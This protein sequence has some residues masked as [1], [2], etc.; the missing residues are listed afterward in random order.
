[1]F[2]AKPD[3][4]YTDASTYDSANLSNIELGDELGAGVFIPI[5]N[6]FRY[7]GSWLTR[8]C[9]DSIDVCERVDSASS[10]FGALRKSIFSSV[11]ISLL[12]KRFVYNTLILPV[13][14]YGS[15]TWCL[16][17]KSFNQLRKFHA[18][19]TRAMCRVNLLHTREHRISTAELL[20]R[21]GLNTID[22]IVTRN[23]LRWAGHVM[24]MGSERLPRKMIT[25][26]VCNPRPRGA[27]EFTYGRGLYKA[28]K[29]TNIPKGKWAT[30]V[31]DRPRWREMINSL[32]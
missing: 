23:Q 29:K 3:Q 31:Q 2:V 17:E 14:L 8:D 9:R 32:L 30:I 13:L 20:G 10:A 26:W 16:T 12:A 27:P 6:K 4:M 19:C 25:S 7:L 24:R 5:V 11:K 1:M 21:I 28:L 18:R 22:S 15:D